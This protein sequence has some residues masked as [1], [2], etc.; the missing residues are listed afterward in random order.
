MNYREEGVQIMAGIQP[1][2]STLQTKLVGML[3]GFSFLTALIV[4]GLSIYLSIQSS[5][6]KTTESNTT[7]ALQL[8]SE[9]NR[10]MDDAKGLTETLAAS[11]E[12]ISLD[13]EK[14]KSLIAAAQ[15][16]IHSLN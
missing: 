16:K 5:E 12:V 9:I 2:K 10:F 3:I 13:A 7:I 8:S 11:P 15:Q 1:G 4:G 6:Q 14:A